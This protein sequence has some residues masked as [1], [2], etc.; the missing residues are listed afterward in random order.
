MGWD[1]G[2]GVGGLI[3]LV[4]NHK[5]LPPHSALKPQLCS[6][7]NFTLEYISQQNRSTRDSPALGAQLKDGALHHPQALLPL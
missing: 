5:H 3:G 4:F 7:D 1:L 6:P 2:R